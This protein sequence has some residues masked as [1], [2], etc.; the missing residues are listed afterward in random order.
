MKGKN[1][2]EKIENY[3]CLQKFVILLEVV[4][5]KSSAKKVFLKSSQ[6]SQANECARV[7]F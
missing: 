5:R 1:H 7:S 3:D 4:P 6:N 2:W